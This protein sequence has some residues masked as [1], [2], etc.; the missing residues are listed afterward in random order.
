MADNDSVDKSGIFEWDM[1]LPLSMFFCVVFGALCI[2][3][4]TPRMYWLCISLACLCETAAH[5]SVVKSKI[6]LEKVKRSVALTPM[7]RELNGVQQYKLLQVSS[8]Q[9]IPYSSSSLH[10][11]ILIR[12]IIFFC[13]RRGDKRFRFVCSGAFL[14]SRS[15]TSSAYG[16]S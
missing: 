3:M 5:V 7:N 8:D 9:I 4:R 1:C 13:R 15:H 2:V 16:R 12:T 10:A 14:Y 6:F 11:Q